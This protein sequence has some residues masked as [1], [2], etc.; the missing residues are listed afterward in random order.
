VFTPI[1]DKAAKL[2]QQREGT[3]DESEEVP[4]QNLQVFHLDVVFLLKEK[5]GD[6]C[7]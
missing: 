2:V 6:K 7:F 3:L 5:K 1:L 4:L